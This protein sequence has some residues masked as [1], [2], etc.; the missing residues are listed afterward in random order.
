MSAFSD[1]IA[2]S[3]QGTDLSAD[4]TSDLIDAMLLGEAEESAVGELLLAL[5]RKGEAV[6]ELVGAAAAMRK[7]M[8]RIPHSHDTL[9]D[10]CGTGGSESGTFNISTAIAIVA[11]A[12]GVAVAKHGIAKRRA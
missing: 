2:K 3:N 12:A 7:H 9:L 5:K 8:T 1:A 11:A 6:S 10:T 4:Q